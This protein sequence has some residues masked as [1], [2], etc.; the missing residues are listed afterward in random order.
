MT[1]HLLR[2]RDSLELIA[3]PLWRG[4]D[5]LGGGCYTHSRH[6]S[7]KPE[8]LIKVL[9]FLNEPIDSLVNGFAVMFQ[10]C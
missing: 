6:G 5:Y 4:D 10:G 1:C 9:I 2:V 7:D 8:K 3:G